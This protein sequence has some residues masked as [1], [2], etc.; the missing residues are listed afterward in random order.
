[1]KPMQFFLIFF[2]P[3]F[4]YGE[5]TA[6]H[7]FCIIVQKDIAIIKI[8]QEGQNTTKHRKELQKTQDSNIFIL[9]QKTAYN[10]ATQ[11]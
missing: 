2:W 1:M 9:L 8:R 11:Q 7:L 4:V 10:L 5:T 3:C 6:N